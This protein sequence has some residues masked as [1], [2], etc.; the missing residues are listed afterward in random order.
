MAAAAAADQTKALQEAC[1][2]G[3]LAAVETLLAAG[4][5]DVNDT[6][7]HHSHYTP[8]MVTFENASAA[9][10]DTRIAI[11]K[12]LL[13][14]GAD[15]NKPVPDTR[16]TPLSVASRSPVE[17]VEWCLDSGVDLAR[18]QYK[19]VLQ[20]Y[21]Y[22][23]YPEGALLLVER[24]VNL[25][26]LFKVDKL[27]NLIVRNRY[28]T[29]LHA[30]I[31]RGLSIPSRTVSSL[32]KAGEFDA[33]DDAFRLNPDMDPD[34]EIEDEPII[35]HAIRTDNVQLVK[36]LLEK[37]AD[38]KTGE[39]VKP[40]II[41]AIDMFS[42]DMVETLLGAGVDPMLKDEDGDT[43]MDFLAAIFDD[44][45][46]NPIA[47]EEMLV[48]LL[49]AGVRVHPRIVRLMEEFDSFVRTKIVQQLEEVGTVAADLPPAGADAA[50]PAANAVAANAVAGAATSAAAPTSLPFR[51]F[52][53]QYREEMPIL[54]VP[55]GTL[56]Y[57]SF[58]L[59]DT[60]T[61]Q[62]IPKFMAGILPFT[63]Q[64][65]Q[66]GST[67]HLKGCIDQMA[68]KFFYSNPV[69]GPALG[70]A[71]APFTVTG[72]FEA[73]RDM[74][75][76]LLMTPA[77]FHRREGADHPE[78]M[79]CNR[80]PTTVC[81]CARDTQT[82]GTHTC[83]FAY[84]YDT[85]LTP[86]F[87][88][89]NQ[90]DGHIALSK[91]D[92]DA[93]LAYRDHVNDAPDHILGSEEKIRLHRLLST[94]GYSMDIRERPPN[95]EEHAEHAAEVAE[96]LANGAPAPAPLPAI[97]R[98]FV[99]GAPELVLHMFGTDWYAEKT[100]KTFDIS[101]PITDDPTRSLLRYL[102]QFNEGAAD[103][104]A[105]HTPLRLI[106]AMTIGR[107]WDFET[108]AAR[109]TR[110]LIPATIRTNLY[111]RLY[112]NALEATMDP[113]LDAILDTRTGFLLRAS[114]LPILRK[115][116]GEEIPYKDLILTNAPA[117]GSLLERSAESRENP[118]WERKDR[119]LYEEDAVDEEDADENTTATAAAP[120]AAPAP[121]LLGGALEPEPREPAR[122]LEIY[123]LFASLVREAKQPKSNKKQ[124]QTNKRN[125]RATRRN[126]TK[127]NKNRRTNNRRL[128]NTRRNTLR[129]AR[130]P[131]VLLKQPLLV[132]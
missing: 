83:R 23:D 5:V 28:Y 25:T 16:L 36:I 126:Q 1:R 127:T 118:V 53:I 12:A 86:A 49:D 43:A 123:D 26:N 58:S 66:E 7:T 41:L 33:V 93:M 92:G 85:C 34:M 51:M 72:V 9:D 101:V 60:P 97:V 20:D 78:K 11:G 88:Q 54:V 103:A 76:A 70:V 84:G 109:D 35:V 132:H 112:W 69:G 129:N 79:D 38:K 102:L 87:L 82:D 130:L 17:L 27:L 80:L 125:L 24:G 105:F 65:T 50:A 120:A 111:D 42:P 75:F 10:V 107:I 8:L 15:I 46:M 52:E 61:L 113:S 91:S 13:E 94:Y 39:D 63:T 114:K 3:D 44:R 57:N 119:L 55:R 21:V 108:G 99:I 116:S 48:A 56:F 22:A 29:L 74:R 4:H 6:D 19:E 18:P 67:L 62:D 45:A 73:R 117:A 95:A 81:D 14:A 71:M 89:R 32:L 77:P 115:P 68:Q 59:L 110:A 121:T 100:S 31:K 47:Y 131:P 96:A 30:M 104:T 37:G 106:R 90:L 98:R 64:V 2:D 124:I 128:R 122:L 40:L